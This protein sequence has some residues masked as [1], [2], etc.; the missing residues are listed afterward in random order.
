MKKT[1]L[2]IPEVIMPTFWEEKILFSCPDCGY[3]NTLEFLN[4]EK[5]F[6][7][8]YQTDM[9]FATCPECDHNHI[10]LG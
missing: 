1:N 7:E 9:Y 10:I 8:F 3:E 2:K 6:S 5:K 4:L